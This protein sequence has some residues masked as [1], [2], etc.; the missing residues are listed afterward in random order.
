MVVCEGAAVRGCVS[1]LCLSLGACAY[2]PA[3]QERARVEDRLRSLP[4]VINVMVACDGALLATD[5]LCASLTFTNDQ[6]IHFGRVGTKSFGAAASAVVVTKAS[7]LMPRVAS[8]AGVA[9]PNFHRDAE[10]GHHF[11]PPLVDL[12]DAV[13]RYR[14]VLKEIQYWP[15]CPQFYDVQ[16]HRGASYRYCARR[17]D[18]PEEPPSPPGCQ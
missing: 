2:T 4:N 8:C 14:E 18:A 15:Q 10:L 9:P 11:H 6:T 13:I 7:G 17:V 3:A 1:A 12:P 5:T 16:D